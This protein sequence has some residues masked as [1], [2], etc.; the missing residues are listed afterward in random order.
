MRWQSSE[1]HDD[2][3]ALQYHPSDHHMLLSGGD[4]GLLGVFDTTIQDD[5]ESLFQAFNHGEF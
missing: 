4:D 5:N 1:N 3:T 2:I